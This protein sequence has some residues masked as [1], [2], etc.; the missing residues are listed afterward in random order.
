MKPHVVH[1]GNGYWLLIFEDK[2]P[3]TIRAVSKED[4]V[5]KWGEMYEELQKDLQYE[6]GKNNEK[7]NNH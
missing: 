6:R 4:A 7:G 2:P 5:H 3:V 1:Q